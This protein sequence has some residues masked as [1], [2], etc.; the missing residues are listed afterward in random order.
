VATNVVVS[1]GKKVDY[2]KTGMVFITSNTFAQN[3]N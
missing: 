1:R 2:P 3:L